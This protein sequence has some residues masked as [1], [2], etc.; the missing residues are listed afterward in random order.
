M[1]RV[2]HSFLELVTYCA[3]SVPKVSRT[4]AQEPSAGTH[5]RLGTQS[6]GLNRLA[7]AQVILAAKPTAPIPSCCAPGEGGNSFVELLVVLAF[8]GIL[9][10][11][12]APNLRPLKNPLHT[13]SEEL[14]AFFKQS[15][16]KAMATTRSYIVEPQSA[17][18]I[19]AKFA[20]SCED[21][22][23]TADHSLTFT[24]P[25]EVRLQNTD[26]TTCFTSRGFA[27]TQASVSLSM[28]DSEPGQSAFELVEVFMGGAVR[29]RP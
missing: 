5:F 10:A 1:N 15:R 16:A 3:G 17:G 13:S 27:Q 8:I 20:N 6:I 28:L 19:I 26:W 12:A 23:P 7:K 2:K 14:V 21:A 9:L 4:G 22:A 11:T 25:S 29:V 24:L 18:K